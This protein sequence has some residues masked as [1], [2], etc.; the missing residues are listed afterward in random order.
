[1]AKTDATRLAILGAGPIGLEAALY[2]HH[3]QLPFTVYERGRVAEHLHRWGH[4]KL[5]SPFGMNATSLGLSA[6]R[7]ANPKHE[8]PSENN[9]VT[10]REHVE[11][12]L[13]PLAKTGPL[14][15]HIR[16]DTQVL[17]VSRQGYLKSDMLG[18]SKVAPRSRQPF[19]IL[20]RSNK[21]QERVEEA[22]IILDCTGTYGQHRW[23]GAGGI[24]AIGELT[25]EPHIA[26]GLEDIAGTR[27]STYAGKN[28]LVVG[29]GY[30]AATTV[31]NLSALAEKHPDTWVYWLA[32]G[33][34]T[35][36]IKRITNDPL[37]ERDRLAV[38]A[39][40]L[41]TRGE[42]N[43]EFHSQTLIELA[44]WAGPD[45]GFKVTAKTAGKT[46][47]WEVERLIANVG[48]TPETSIYRELQIHECYATL[49]P[50]N[51]SAA[52]LKQSGVDCLQIPPQGA[53]ALRNPE[54]NFFIL[55]SKSYGRNSH[56]L[57]K[58]GFE[59][60]REVF[61][62]ITGKPDLNLYKKT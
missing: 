4:V 37:K 30:S 46:K 11:S 25:A 60:I 58:N 19:R 36:P 14:R 15:E 27:Q 62:F 17:Y 32:R 3:L 8:F 42:G 29:S 28:V 7:Q 1:M 5:F 39:N 53:E 48:Y 47:T 54:P 35:Q 22:D 40:T 49:G 52:L 33:N 44:E 26:Y 61:T 56:F 43:V 6:I 13:D 16:Q 34:S 10:G 38:R 21:T 12:Y 31:C 45:R 23:M 59:Q 55:G 2:A 9:C 50:M 18:D 20:L 51:L 57:L 24:P 41:A